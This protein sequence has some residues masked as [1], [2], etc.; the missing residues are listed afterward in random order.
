MGK[1]SFFPLLGIDELGE[2]GEASQL[3]SGQQTT[4]EGVQ[5]DLSRENTVWRLFL[6]AIVITAGGR[7]TWFDLA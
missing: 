6:N 2:K 1:A 7:G 5:Y 4:S 3:G